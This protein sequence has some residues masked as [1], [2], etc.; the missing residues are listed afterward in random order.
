MSL[1]SWV[2]QFRYFFRGNKKI[3]C[4]YSFIGYLGPEVLWFGFTKIKN[5]FSKIET[6]SKIQP[7][8]KTFY[9]TYMMLKKVQ[10]TNPIFWYWNPDSNP[11]F[12]LK[13]IQKRY[14]RRGVLPLHVF[15]QIARPCHESTLFQQET[16]H[17]NQRDLTINSGHFL[18]LVLLFSQSVHHYF[19][20][21]Q[22]NFSVWFRRGFWGLEWVGRSGSEK[23]VEI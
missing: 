9:I 7:N 20:I 19:K 6:K 1:I 23:Q 10:N 22:I 14:T 15:K 18:Q 5:N 21:H 3:N 13:I 12:V 2:I 11:E 8:L 4:V 17:Q 16:I